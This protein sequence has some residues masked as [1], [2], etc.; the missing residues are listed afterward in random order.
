MS[1]MCVLCVAVG[2]IRHN[3]RLHYHVERAD[4]YSWG[5]GR[6]NW[7]PPPQRTFAIVSFSYW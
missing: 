1:H 5:R 4:P 7:T 2:N 6:A 3:A